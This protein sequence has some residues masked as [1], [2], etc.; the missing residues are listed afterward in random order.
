[1]LIIQQDRILRRYFIDAPLNRVSEYNAA[2]TKS[3]MKHFAKENKSS[4]V[5]ELAVYM[6][7]YGSVPLYETRYMYKDEKTGKLILVDKAGIAPV[8]KEKLDLKDEDLYA[9][10]IDNGAIEGFLSITLNDAGTAEYAEG[11]QRYRIFS[12]SL[13]FLFFMLISSMVIIALYHNYSKKMRLARDM[14][15]VKASND[16]LTGLYTHAYFVRSLKIEIERS[17]IYHGP[18]ALAMIDVDRFKG[19]NDKYGHV[20]GD[21][22]LQEVARVIKSST[23]SSDICARYGG[24]EFSIVIPS[25]P[26]SEEGNKPKSMTEFITEVDNVTERIRKSVEEN[27]LTLDGNEVTVTISMGVAFFHKGNERLSAGELTERADAALY[28]AKETGRNRIIIDQGTVNR[29]V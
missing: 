4:S 5:A 9:V 27:K 10:S 11:L 16:G 18:I 22:V 12:Y 3:L 7:K 26:A 17:R 25:V 14:A 20:A 2:L 1:M 21:L 23:R 28:Q 8:V 29:G 24:E 6:K 13:R 19:Y 15:E